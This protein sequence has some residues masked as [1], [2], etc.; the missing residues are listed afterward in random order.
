MDAEDK[1]VLIVE[2]LPATS[3]KAAIVEK[4]KDET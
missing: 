4:A 2:I 1:R 3:R